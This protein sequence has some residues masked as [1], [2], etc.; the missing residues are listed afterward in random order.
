ML[1]EADDKKRA[2]LNC[3]AHLLTRIPYQEVPYEKPILPKRAHSPTI[4]GP[5]FRKRCTCPTTTRTS[6]KSF[7][8]P[9]LFR[10]GQE[11]S[12]RAARYGGRFDGKMKMASG[13]DRL[14]AR[15]RSWRPQRCFGTLLYLTEG[16]ERG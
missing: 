13:R 16:L 2:R 1:V 5:R 15:A 10:G 12:R 14:I 9:H 7:R 4:T 11:V 8:G 6:R 3:I